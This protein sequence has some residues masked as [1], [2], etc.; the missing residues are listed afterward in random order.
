MIFLRWSFKALDVWKPNG[1]SLRSP[2]C[3]HPGNG[4]NKRLNTRCLILDVNASMEKNSVKTVSTEPAFTMMLAKL[5]DTWGG[6]AFDLH[7][8]SHYRW[9]MSF[10][11]GVCAHGSYMCPISRRQCDVLCPK[12]VSLARS[13]FRHTI[14]LRSLLWE[15]W[16]RGISDENIVIHWP[17]P[18]AE[19]FLRRS[20]EHQTL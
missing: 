8:C 14:L 3:V 7:I 5:V 1:L 6:G 4:Q 12:I 9:S 2:C 17:H 20:C 13:V 10:W 18:M 15:E 19:W 11:G 16:Q